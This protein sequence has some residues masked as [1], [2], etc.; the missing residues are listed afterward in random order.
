MRRCGG[1]LFRLRLPRPGNIRIEPAGFMSGLDPIAIVG[2]GGVF[3]DAPD[4]DAFWRNIAAGHCSIKP[5]PPARWAVDA[6]LAYRLAPGIDHVYS[7]S[8][9]FVD[10]FDLDP[11]GMAIDSDVLRSLDPVHR[12][13]LEAGRQ[14]I[15]SVVAGAADPSRTGVVLAAIALPTDGASAVTGAVMNRVFER[16][17]FDRA[18]DDDGFESLRPLISPE[19]SRVTYYPA[20]ILSRAF[21]LTGGA[22]TLDAACASSLYAIKIACDELQSGR[23]DA[24][25]AGGVSRPD[26]LFTQM[27]FSQLRALSKTGR[28]RP[29][30][31]AADGLVVGEGAG[32]VV[33]KR[34]SD[35][36]RDGDAVLAVIRGIGWSNDTAGSLLAADAEGQLRA[37]RAA[38]DVAGWRPADVDLI[39]CH[40]T[41]T[42]LGDATELRGMRTLWADCA[43]RAGQ[44]AIGSVKS[45]IGHLLTAANAAGL[46]KTLLAMRSETL[47][48]SLGFEHAPAGVD[49]ADSPF[50]VQSSAARWS[51]RDARTPRRAAVSG[52][53]FGGINAH[54][55]LEE[56][57]EN[58]LNDRDGS[59]PAA[60]TRGNG[61]AMHEAEKSVAIVGMDARFGGIESPRMFQE[62]VLNG[63]RAGGHRAPN[64]LRSYESIL[65]DAGMDSASIE[66]LLLD[67]VD[68][69]AGALRLPPNEIRDVLPQQ[70]I[71]LQSVRAAIDDAKWHYQS[72]AERTGVFVGIEFDWNTTNYHHRWKL[73]EQ[74]RDWARRIG[75]HPDGD[76]FERWLR[77]LRDA[78]S[79]PLTA[80]RVQGALGNIVASRIAREFG[81]GGPSFAISADEL[82]GLWALRVAINALNRGEID[83]AIVA[84]ADLPG[85]PRSL[86]ARQAAGSIDRS[87]TIA[88]G[89]AALILR[90]SDDVDDRIGPAYGLIRGVALAGPSPTK[91]RRSQFERTARSACEQCDVLPETLTLIESAGGCAAGDGDEIDAL[92]AVFGDAGDAGC[93]ISGIGSVIGHAGAATGLAQ[94]AAASICVGRRIVPACGDGGRWSQCI[95]G[96]TRFFTARQPQ[97]WLTDAVE[98]PRRAG[99]SVS[100]SDGSCGFVVVEEAVST[101]VEAETGGT[102]GRC[103]DDRQPIGT[104]LVAVFGVAGDRVDAIREGLADLKRF[105]AGA[106]GPV[107]RVVRRWHLSVGANH[108]RGA[109][110]V[111]I[112]ARDLDEVARAIASVLRHITECA[113]QPLDGR[114]GVYYSPKPLAATGRVALVFPGSGNHFT[115]MGLALGAHWPSVL[116]ATERDARRLRRQMQPALFAPQRLDWSDGWRAEVRAKQSAD[117]AGLIMAQVSCSVLSSDILR[118]LGVRCDAVIGYSLGETASLF[119]SGAWRDRDEIL[120]RMEASN[121][122]RS[123]LA[124][125]CDAARRYWRLNHDESVDWCVMTVGA[126]VDVVRGEIDGDPFVFLLIVNTPD[127]CVIGGRRRAVESCIERLRCRTIEIVGASTVH[128]PIAGEVADAYRAL[129]ELETTSPDGVEVYSAANARTFNVTQQAAADSILRQALVGFD[130]SRVIERAYAD[131]IRVF[132][133]AGPQASCTRMIGGIL[134]GK[135][136]VAVSALV[137]GADEVET[138]I[139]TVGRLFA[140]RAV[141]DLD[142]LYGD[143]NRSAAESITTVVSKSKPVISVPTSMTPPVVSFPSDATQPSREHPEYDTSVGDNERVTVDSS[144]AVE[145]T[146][147][148]ADIPSPADGR[149]LPVAMAQTGKAAADAHDAFLRFSRTAMGGL[150]AG[151]TLQSRL[152][153]HASPTARHHAVGSQPMRETPLR[154][155]TPQASAVPI[156]F[157]RDQCME[158]A[159]GSLANVLGP[160]FADV[161]TYPVRVRLPDEPLMLVDRIVSVDGEMASLGSGRIVTEHDVSDGAW[162]LDGGRAPVCI[163]VEAGQADLFLCSYLGIDLAVRG[164]RSYRLLD[165]KIVFH[166]DL[167]RCGEVIRYDIVID[168]FV[169]QGETYMFFF[170]YQATIDG[171]PLLTMT[172]GCAGFFTEREIAES[173]GILDRPIDPETIGAPWRPMV[174]MGRESYDENQVDAIRRGDLESCFGEAF[175]GIVVPP[176]QRIGDERM[177]LVHRVASL[178]PDGG[179]FGR[180]MIRA[181]ADIHPDDWFLT[182]HFVDDM[183]MPGTLMYECC[184]HALRIFAM[185]MGWVTND[186]EARWAPVLEQPCQLR[187]RGPVTPHTRVAA[188]ELHVKSV[189]LGPEPR[190]IADAHMY[191]DDRKVV[192]VS[193]LSLRLVGANRD[194]IQRFWNARIAARPATTDSIEVAPFDGGIEPIGGGRIEDTVKPA[195]FDRSRILAFAEGKPSVAFGEPY[196][197]FDSRRRLARLPRPPYAFLDRITEVQAEAWKTAPGGWIEGQYDVPP[198]A[199]YFAANRQR[200][201]PFAVLLE[202]ALQPCGWFAAYVGSALRSDVD[203]SFRNLDGSATMYEEITPDGGTLS[204]RVRLTHVSHAGGMII[205]KFDMQIWR[206]G[207]IVYDGDTAFGFFSAT[208]LAQQIGVRDA[209]DRVYVPSD[210]ELNRSVAVQLPRAAP[211]SPDDATVAAYDPLSLPGEALLMLDAIDVFV[212]DGGPNGL[213]FIRASKTVDPNEW[214]FDAHFYQDPVCPGSLGLESFIQLLKVAAIH[215]WGDEL[216]RTHRFESMAIGSRHRWTYRGQVIPSNRRV[217]VEAVVSRIEDGDSPLIEANGFLKV[218][219][220]IIYEMIDFALRLV[221]GGS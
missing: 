11:R 31:A 212:P 140:H 167:P 109:L 206:G 41:G 202:I 164:T 88:E 54:L 30:D 149:S 145:S 134:S 56:Y 32:I 61:T 75:W 110:A 27:G 130:F 24:V 141:A 190:I 34:L 53:G 106:T 174:A 69:Q 135:P 136:H 104:S 113:D 180:G 93:G 173:G 218:D 13:T 94:L 111:A 64:R 183:V 12:I 211:R 40:G 143:P 199:W 160:D 196:R 92:Q 99:V 58:V 23:L 91:D 146:V 112:V 166:R 119:A 15:E 4:L 179:R 126:A 150:G 76:A 115:G 171:E 51:R 45:N 163:T 60:V 137:E 120:R 7:A 138:M 213:G 215:R 156:A 87:R 37:M 207:R 73:V 131:G 209:A 201:M 182:C 208:A 172:D 142:G 129:H 83:V 116:R 105:V 10:A 204:T 103:V 49:L 63:R 184:A 161:D 65:A 14:A 84:A 55:L 198:D 151:L 187:C 102:G 47:P 8:A 148:E 70:L 159:V 124:G 52:F 219:G 21:G 189:S 123:E 203:L 197:V 181:E 86:L 101:G 85:D 152:L 200:S 62:F 2:M 192:L 82:S 177:R 18:G 162:Y 169:R 26:S 74:A 57:D 43:W 158:F 28:C 89:A 50:R 100:N 1:R 17:L 175:A 3:P 9:C 80:S 107:E 77:V 188:Y 19:R 195:I 221:R 68:V 96:D 220:V 48:G 38:Y 66:G 71:A 216:G 46:I 178:D 39:E 185:R 144:G 154:E 217:E 194:S 114:D 193:D 186:P 214:F 25:L 29:F 170:R 97:Y 20:S 165:A 44:C 95:N 16:Q 133:E 81:F 42:P 155:V 22:M 59:R 67:Q 78:S 98:G 139:R 79:P 125:C 117:P 6:E 168:R 176:W 72:D 35:A 127:E 36:V 118:H 121:L 90:R 5:V 191:A 210:A 147:R 33:L 205:E 122:F 128:C 157:D 153:K 108:R 132:V